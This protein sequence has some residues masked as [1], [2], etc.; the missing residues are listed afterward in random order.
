[1][2]ASLAINISRPQQPVKQVEQATNVACIVK[3]YG[4]NA[5][6]LWLL[7]CH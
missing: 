2:R 5:A 1:M 4:W 6:F 7:F 3:G